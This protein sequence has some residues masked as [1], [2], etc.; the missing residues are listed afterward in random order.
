[1]S[2]TGPNYAQNSYFCGTMGKMSFSQCSRVKTRRRV[3]VRSRIRAL[4]RVSAMKR[5]LVY[6]YLRDSIV[7][8]ECF[9]WYHQM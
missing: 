3:R 7:K 5:V 8:N 1:M 6:K 9:P 4:V 2:S